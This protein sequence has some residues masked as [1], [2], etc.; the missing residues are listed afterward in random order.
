M[1]ATERA[2]HAAPIDRSTRR[3]SGECRVA[4]SRVAPVA[5]SPVQRTRRHHTTPEP[6]RLDRVGQTGG[7]GPT[8]RSDHRPLPRV[9]ARTAAVPSRT[10]RR[11]R[12]LVGV[13][14]A[15]VAGCGLVVVHDVLAGSSGLPATAD[16][17]RPAPTSGA[18]TALPG[19]TL[20]GIAEQH[21]GDV[22]ID[23]YVEQLVRLNGGSSIVA[24]QTVLLP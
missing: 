5:A 17:G 22:A 11:R 8:G 12:A 21:R 24:G 14:L 9:D 16:S 13:L 10:V 19:D 15:V 1:R 18:V 4:R 2:I 23:R 6:S 7:R 3:R 20:W